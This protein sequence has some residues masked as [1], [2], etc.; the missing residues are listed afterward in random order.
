M[1]TKVYSQATEWSTE[2]QSSF[3][4][5]SGLFGLDEPAQVTTI[6]YRNKGF[7]VDGFHSFSWKEPRKTVQSFFGAGYT[8]RF[9]SLS[10][11]TLSIKNDF[12]FNRVANNG[13]FLRPMLIGKWT[14]NP[15]KLKF[16]NEL[17]LLFVRIEDVRDVGGV[18][19]Q[20][21]LSEN[22]HRFYV[23]GNLGYSF[24]RSDGITQWIWNVGIGKGF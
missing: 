2:L 3:I 23:I 5:I 21:K 19:N 8:F 1:T 20:V 12:A 15:K 17:R 4:D 22:K 9:D 10:T 24:Y 18:V 14:V 11:K 7:F 16:R 13:S 6:Q